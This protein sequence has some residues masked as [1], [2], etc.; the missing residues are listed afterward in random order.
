MFDPIQVEAA[1]AAH[2]DRG[3]REQALTLGWKAYGPQLLGYLVTM[4][5]DEDLAREALAQ[6]AEQAWKGLAGFRR[7]SSFRAWAY[8]LT[9]NA[10]LLQLRARARRRERALATGELSEVAA[11]TRAPTPPHART[12]LRDRVTAL[13][14]RLA[15]EEQ[16]L[17]TLRV[18]RGLAWREIAHVFGD[19]ADDA[20]LRK[21]YE[22][23]KARL[24][25]L[26]R[27]EGI[28][29]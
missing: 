7:E 21:R 25:E 5:R 1:I 24:R 20:T 28:V 14:E 19:G 12:S 15:P 23:A 10:A 9:W 27:A 8:R 18:D 26:A 29:E 13:R 6:A 11:P 2:L 4:L 22:R 17:L 3:E 16:T